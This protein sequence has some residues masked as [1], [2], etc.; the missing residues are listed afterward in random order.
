MLSSFEAMPLKTQLN[1]FQVFST[2]ML[3]FMLKSSAA[4]VSWKHF[5]LSTKCYKPKL[6]ETELY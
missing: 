5:K 6:V 1:L 3:S 2:A 4:S